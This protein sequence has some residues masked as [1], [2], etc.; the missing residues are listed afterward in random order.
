[1]ELRAK[2]CERSRPKWVLEGKIWPKWAKKVKRSK[3][4][5]HFCL[6]NTFCSWTL[7]CLI[8]CTVL[9]NNFFGVSHNFF[10]L[11][12]SKSVKKTKNWKFLWIFSPGRSPLKFYYIMYTPTKKYSASKQKF[13]GF[14]QIFPKVIVLQKS[15]IPHWKA[16]IFSFLDV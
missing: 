15:Y 16:L 12:R 10:P 6:Y 7:G 13:D 4:S 14:C 11:F 3:L 2:F 9:P 1:M 8:L 5:S